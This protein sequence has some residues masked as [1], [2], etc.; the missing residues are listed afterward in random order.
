MEDGGRK[1]GGD[2]GQGEEAA[3]QRGLIDATAAEPPC[4][5]EPAGILTRGQMLCSLTFRGRR[6][7]IR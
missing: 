1:G 7:F 2:E 3:E 6:R 4:E 5:G